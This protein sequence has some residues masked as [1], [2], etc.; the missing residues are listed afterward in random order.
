MQGCKAK[1]LVENVLTHARQYRDIELE[2]TLCYKRM[3]RRDEQDH[4]DACPKEEVTCDCGV[5]LQ[6]ELRT[7]VGKAYDRRRKGACLQLVF[8]R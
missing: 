8:S 7:R 3:R 6:R 1:V 4:R 5:K 2:C